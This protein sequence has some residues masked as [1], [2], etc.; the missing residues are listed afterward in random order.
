MR[1]KAIIQNHYPERLHNTVIM[2]DGLIKNGL[3]EE[4]ITILFDYVPSPEVLRLK[5][6]NIQVSNKN[7]PINWWHAVGSILDADYVALLCDDLTLKSESIT[8]L[9]VLA[10]QNPD[11][12]VL[13]YEGGK[14]ADTDKPYT[15]TTSHKVEKSERADFLIRFYFARPKALLRAINLYNLKHLDKKLKGHDDLLLSLSNLC[16]IAPTTDVTGWEELPEHGVAFSKRPEH[17]DE[18]NKLVFFIKHLYGD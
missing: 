9:T 6:T 14:F 8:Q 3:K 17:Y 13:G 18:R 1:V 12:G 4:D 7:L 16:M 11:I 15:D 5:K 2:V 10:D